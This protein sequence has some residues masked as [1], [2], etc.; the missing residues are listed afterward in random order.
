MRQRLGSL[1]AIS[2]FICLANG[3]AVQAAFTV[4]GPT[5][6]LLAADSPFD[7]SG[8]GATFFLEDFEDLEANT[9]G[10]SFV[11]GGIGRGASVDADDGSID[12][13]GEVA[14]SATAGILTS[15]A[16]SFG[17]R[18]RFEFDDIALGRYPTH[19][20]FV[21]T[22]GAASLG[23]ITVYSASGDN[24][25]LDTTGTSYD[26]STARDDRFFGF[27]DPHGV[28]AIEIDKGINRHLFPRNFPR[29]DHIQYGVPEPSCSALVIFVGVI[30]TAN[31]L[32]SLRRSSDESL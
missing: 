2:L 24:V 1:A 18:A 5:P 32:R 21:M 25:V 15:S 16:G 29:V 28:T 19:V 27:I 20:G 22:A 14:N 13:S 17:T 23:Q 7:L 30:N 26:A 11:Y 6:Y 31:V 4:L 9:P 12:G 10:L 3:A 8:L